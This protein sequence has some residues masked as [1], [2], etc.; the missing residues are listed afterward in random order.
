MLARVNGTELYWEMNGSGR[1]VVLLHGGPG[2]DHTYFRPWLDGLA[3]GASLVYYDQRGSGRSSRGDGFDGVILRTLVDDLE[4]LRTHLGL[5]RFVLLGHSFGACLALAYAL[6][7]ADRLD[8]MALC[9]AAP[10]LEHVPAALVR[11]ADRMTSEQRSILARLTQ[12]V[13]DDAF[14]M[15]AWQTLLPLYFADYRA[16]YERAVIGRLRCS[17]A[18]WNHL[19]D[20]ADELNAAARHHR[21]PCPV[22][23]LNGRHDWFATEEQVQRLQVVLPGAH[24]IEFEH[25][26]HFPFIEQPEPFLTAVRAWLASL[27]QWS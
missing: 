6:H 5:E 18:A 20:I 9:A 19:A 24:L 10:S 15:H 14:L 21:A 7:Y 2:F 23:L 27:P 13:D 12:Q 16:E 26:G 4:G 25:S 8:G 11:L 22:L 1:P 17:A 3:D